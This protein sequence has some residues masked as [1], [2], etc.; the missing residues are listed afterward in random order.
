MLLQRFYRDLQRFITEKSV[1]NKS[2]GQ[3]DK[4][5]SGLQKGRILCEPTHTRMHLDDVLNPPGAQ[6]PIV[7]GIH[8]WSL[9]LKS[10]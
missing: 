1:D 10:I 2:S 4:R 3:L 5:Q 9:C 6:W 8:G 7:G